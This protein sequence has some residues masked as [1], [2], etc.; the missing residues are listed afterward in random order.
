VRRSSSRWQRDGG[1]WRIDVGKATPLLRRPLRT[2]PATVGKHPGSG[3]RCGSCSRIQRCV[4]ACARRKQATRSSRNVSCAWWSTDGR[5]GLQARRR[6]RPETGGGGARPGW[7]RGWWKGRLGLQTL[8]APFIWPGSGMG[9]MG[10][11][12]RSRPVGPGER[13]WADRAGGV[14]GTAHL[15]RT[16]ARRPAGLG[17]PSMRGRLGRHSVAGPDFFNSC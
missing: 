13:T 5:G 11:R 2:T 7:L 14:R 10:Q 3:S 9:Q 16:T 4:T 1:W 6:C 17:R 8:T 12:L 15:G